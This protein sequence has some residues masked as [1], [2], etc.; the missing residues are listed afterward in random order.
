MKRLNAVLPH[1]PLDAVLTTGL[2]FFPQIK[3]DAARSIYAVAGLVGGLDQRKRSVA[4][5]L[6]LA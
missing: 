2:T 5:L 4:T 6:M 1:E 3:K